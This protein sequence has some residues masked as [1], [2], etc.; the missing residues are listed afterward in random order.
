MC[1]LTVRHSERYWVRPGGPDEA[2]GG[3]AHTSVEDQ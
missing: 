2:W 1:S 3:E